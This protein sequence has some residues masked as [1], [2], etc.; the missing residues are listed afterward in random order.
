M[1]T[2]GEPAAA[3]AREL[4]VPR[5]WLHKWADEVGK[6]GAEAFGGSGRSR[7]SNDEAAVLKR[8]LTRLKEGNEIIKKDGILR[9]R[10]IVKYAWMDGMPDH[11]VRTMCRALCVSPSGFHAWKAR[12]P[13]PRR[14]AND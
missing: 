7:A 4:G 13:S 8:E 12:K 6:K 5:N 2:I 11:G 9:A 3:V 14:L 1:Q 10:A